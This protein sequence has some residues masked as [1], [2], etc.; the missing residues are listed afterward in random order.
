MQVAD[1]A[2]P[3]TRSTVILA[4]ADARVDTPLY[5]SRPF[6]VMDAPTIDADRLAGRVT[7]SLA[8]QN[9]SRRDAPA[10]LRIDSTAGTSDSKRE[11]LGVVP[12]GARSG[13]R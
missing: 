7:L 11:D 8:V 12:S 9:T 3:R 6:E 13:R 10:V 5:I 1:R 4:M 2:A